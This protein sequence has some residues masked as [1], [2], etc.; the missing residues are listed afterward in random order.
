MM[1]GEPPQE[2]INRA[3]YF[4]GMAYYKIGDYP[5]CLTAFA[6]ADE[7]SPFYPYILYNDALARLRMK[8]I[9]GAVRTFERLFELPPNSEDRRRV[10]EEGRLSLGYLYYELGNYAAAVQQFDR[11]NPGGSLYAQAL[12]AKGWALSQTADW[13]GAAAALSELIRRFPGHSESQE[14]RFLLGRCLVNLERYDEAV[15]VYDQLIALSPEQKEVVS[16]VA[17]VNEN[18]ERERKRIEKQ[19]MELLVAESRLLDESALNGD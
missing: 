14:G 19:Q 9:D 13:S 7:K 2:V 6:A 1:R 12:L 18:I 8:D 16:T 3:A 15:K 17:K 11:V 5:R 4:A 10:I